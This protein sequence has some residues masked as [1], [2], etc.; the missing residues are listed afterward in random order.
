MKQAFVFFFLFAFVSIVSTAQKT[1]QSFYNFEPLPYPYEALERAIDAQTMEIHYDRHHRGYFNNFIEAVKGTDLFGLSPEEL[2]G[3]VSK[4]SPVIR[5]NGGGHYNHTLFWN[6]LSPNGGGGPKGPLAEAIQSTFG[7]FDNFK[8]EFEK[9]A[10]N[11]FGSG[12]AWLSVDNT[13]KL[14][15]S[16]TPN[17]DNPL[18][19]VAEQRGYPILGV[20][21]WEHAYYLRYQNRRGAYL[22]AIW[23]IINWP[24]VQKRY[25]SVMKK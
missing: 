23:D 3:Q 5:N 25:E 9:A 19:D 11:R 20:D 21:V 13:G 12:W 14:F 18:M 24:E 10:L 17:Q 2:F 16:S 22:S 1:P 15:I 4:L 7:S 6:I 8:K